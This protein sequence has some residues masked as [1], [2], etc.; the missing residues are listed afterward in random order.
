M[1]APWRRVAILEPA[2]IV[3]ET[4]LLECSSI[5]GQI[6]ENKYCRA[7]CPPAL[8]FIRLLPP[9]SYLFFPGVV[10]WLVWLLGCLWFR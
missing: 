10:P 7:D 3:L 1:P 8:V 4:D 6:L 2:E 9:W 5:R